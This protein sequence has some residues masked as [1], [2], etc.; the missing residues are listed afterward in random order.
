M[1][2]IPIS[3]IDCGLFGEAG[4]TAILNFTAGQR[5]RQQTMNNR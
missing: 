1:T 3:D 2:R 4:A 5:P